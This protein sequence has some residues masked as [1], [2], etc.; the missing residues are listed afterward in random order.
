M[1]TKVALFVIGALLAA[2]LA[3]AGERI[4]VYP[5]RGQSE[6]QMADDR[7]HCHRWAVEASGFDPLA[8]GYDQPRLVRV[9]VP[10]NPHSGA[11]GRGLVG[12]AIAGAALGEITDDEPARGAAIGAIVGALLGGLAEREGERVSRQVAAE[13]QRLQAR[14]LGVGRANYRRALAACLEGRGYVV[15]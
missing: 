1:N 15:N 11:A 10:E 14:E 9:P 12:G 6:Q 13:E 8:V 3:R 5:A 2:P 4:F 7:Y